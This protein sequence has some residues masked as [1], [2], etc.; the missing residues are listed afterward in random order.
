[1]EINEQIIS[2]GRK[3]LQKYGMLSEIGPVL[4]VKEDKSTEQI[5]TVYAIS[6]E[7]METFRKTI[8]QNPNDS[9]VRV[10]VKMI[11]HVKDGI[12]E[13]ELLSMTSALGYAPELYAYFN[14]LKRKL[15][16]IK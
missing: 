15:D 1:M 2:E 5:G 9:Y 4:N 12:T 3:L 8:E 13:D 14:N 10:I 16:Y 6:K 7:T 11:S